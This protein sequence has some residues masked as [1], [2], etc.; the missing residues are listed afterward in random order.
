MK[1]FL[2]TF[3]IILAVLAAAMSVNGDMP[4]ELKPAFQECHNELLGTPHE[5]PTGPP[6]MDDPKVKCIHACVA[7]KIGHM[8]DG[9]IVA[10]KEI[11]SA[12]QHIPNADNSLTE[13]ITECAN[14]ANEQSDECEVSA[15]F[16][17]CIV[18]KVGPPEHHH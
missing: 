14:K 8:V 9:K 4:G 15:A 1:A 18:E 16:H 2:C 13:K 17:K 5:E 7:K 3:S 6:N 11:E 12:K 10:K